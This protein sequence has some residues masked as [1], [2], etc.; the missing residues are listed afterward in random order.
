MEKR[1]E[2]KKIMVPRHDTLYN[3]VCRPVYHARLLEDVLS[4]P[5]DILCIT[6]HCIYHPFSLADPA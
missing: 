3:R 6:S 5:P 1:A 2:K 4:A